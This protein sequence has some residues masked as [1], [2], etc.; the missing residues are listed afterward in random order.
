MRPPEMENL[1]V[2][3]Q[4]RNKPSVRVW[5]FS[6]TNNPYWNHRSR[7]LTFGNRGQQNN[8]RCLSYYL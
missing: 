2:E 4:T 7:F 6:G 8:A 5:I 1:G 3:G